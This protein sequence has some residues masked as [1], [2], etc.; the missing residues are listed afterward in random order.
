MIK[1]ANTV[2]NRQLTQNSVKTETCANSICHGYE[3]IITMET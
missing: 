1:L 3:E 2:E